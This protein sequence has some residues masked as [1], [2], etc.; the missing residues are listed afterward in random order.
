MDLSSTTV[1]RAAVPIHPK[2]PPDQRFSASDQTA[3]GDGF[4]PWNSSLTSAKSCDAYHAGVPFIIKDAAGT[5]GSHV[6]TISPVSG[7]V[8]GGCR[9]QRENYAY[10]RSPIPRRWRTTPSEAATHSN[11]SA[12]Q[13]PT[14]PAEARLARARGGAGAVGLTERQ[15]CR[16]IA[17]AAPV[18]R[19]GLVLRC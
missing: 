6:I 4:I 17:Q 15:I 14:D 11:A 13:L 5:P 2:P 1:P 7:I 18:G 19:G 3:R 10:E 9:F 8:L 12:G 16:S